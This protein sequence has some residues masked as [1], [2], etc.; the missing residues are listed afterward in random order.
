MSEV[1]LISPMLDG[2]SMGE[3]FSNHHGVC[4]CPAMPGNSDSKYIVKIMSIPASQVQLQALL[5]TGAYQS[6]AAARDYFLE[7]AQDI[8]AETDILRKLSKQEGFLPFEDHQ[9]VPKENEVGYDIYLLSGYRRSLARHMRKTNMTHLAAINLGLDMCAALTVS[10]NAGYLYA[11]LKPENIFVCHDREFRIN[12]LGFLKLDSLKYTSMP[13]RYIGT[14]TAP[15]IVDA[16][17]DINPTIDVYA[18]GLI[19]YQVYNGG[20]LPFEGRATGEPRPA[21]AYA[22][23]ELAE[24]ILKACA[25]DPK[26]RWQDPY[27]MGQSLVA[28]M[29]RNG[30]NDT[31]IVTSLEGR[32]SYRVCG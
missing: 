19:L 30:V 18:A 25:P 14:Y 23:Y 2:F 11:D 21:P 32:R 10:R 5:L 9:I 8:V 1:K 24:I 12:D 22:D 7:L 3:P 16:F 17:S 4:C 20:A 26:D 6:E 29:Q 31:P 15:E 13:E 28:Y 27:E